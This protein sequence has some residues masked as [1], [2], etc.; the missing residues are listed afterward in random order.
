MLVGCTPGSLRICFTSSGACLCGGISSPLAS[1]L[2]YRS[3]CLIQITSIISL[4]TLTCCMS[5]KTTCISV[6]SRLFLRGAAPPIVQIYPPISVSEAAAPPESQH[7]KP[8]CIQQLLPNSYHMQ[9]YSNRL[10]KS[11]APDDGGQIRDQCFG[12]HLPAP[13]YFK[14]LVGTLTWITVLCTTLARV[15]QQQ[16]SPLCI[17][18]YNV[19][20]KLRYT[21]MANA[22]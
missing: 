6:L 20:C 2:C 17:S 10:H 15:F 4:G 21:Y 5:Q 18:T 16:L 19:R 3:M 8:I 14:I 22:T 11:D 7:A 13:P 12:L 9:I 1:L